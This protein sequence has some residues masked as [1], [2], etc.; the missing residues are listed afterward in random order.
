MAT[1]TDIGIRKKSAT[2]T[3]NTEKGI[4]IEHAGSSC[5]QKQGQIVYQNL[6]LRANPSSFIL[7]TPRLLSL[8]LSSSL[9]RNNNNN[10]KTSLL[11]A[12]FWS[13]F[14]S[15]T[16]EV[17]LTRIYSATIGFHYA[18]LIIS[19]ALGGLGIGALLTFT[20][21]SKFDYPAIIAAT[22]ISLPLLLAF[23]AFVPANLES[24]YSYFIVSCIPFVLSG[25]ILAKALRGD[26][27]EAP[28]IYFSDL[29]AASLGPPISIVLLYLFPPQT[30]LLASSLAGAA[31]ATALFL[32]Q[33]RR[34]QIFELKEEGARHSSFPRVLSLIVAA[35]LICSA[36]IAFNYSSNALSNYATPLKPALNSAREHGYDQATVWNPISRVDVI[37]SASARPG[38][39]VI[40]DPG[41][42][43][44]I[45][46][47]I[48]DGDASTP[49]LGWNGSKPVLPV[50][51]FMLHIPYALG[52]RTSVL[53]IGSGGGTDI[54]EALMS[55]ASNITAV[56]VN[57]AVVNIVKSYGARAGNIYSNPKVH[58]FI[59]EGRSFLARS[60]AK[61]DLIDMTLVD[62]WAAVSTGAYSTSEAYLYTTNAIQ[63]M[64]DHLTPSGTLVIVRWSFELPKDILTISSA[65]ENDGVPSSEVGSHIAVFSQTRTGEA[66]T[67][68]GSQLILVKKTPF[69]SYELSIM[70]N[71]TP[72]NHFYLPGSNS[73]SIYGKYF[74]NNANPSILMSAFPS[75][76]IVPAT[77]NSPYYFD[78]SKGVPFQLAQALEINL[79]I[80]AVIGII[81]FI[82]RSS[83]KR[84]RQGE[85]GESD[86]SIALPSRWFAYYCLIGLGFILIEVSLFQRLTLL[87]GYPTIAFASL[88]F[89]LLVSSACGSLFSSKIQNRAMPITLG[90]LC[91]LIAAGTLVLLTILPMAIDRT[92]S[93]G[94]FERVGVS[95]LVM[96]PLGVL[97]G[98][99]FPSGLR[100]IS[101]RGY[102]NASIPTVLGVNFIASVIG[103]VLAVIIGIYAGLAFS[104]VVAA[105]CYSIAT[106]IWLSLSTKK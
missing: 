62:S 72:Y 5:T 67:Y 46:S 79:G 49:I 22:A 105:I 14:Q 69:T 103:S 34:R 48:I 1:K 53:I 89:F 41:N 33:K 44:V 47:I 57:P 51:K 56:E 15:I 25:L 6:F 77:D 28:S 38:T 71:V 76:N 55:G 90:I 73:S 37:G 104:L 83:R 86:R 66:S 102:T 24:L 2:A 81:A 93:L 17:L 106:L 94:I 96:A 84:R 87:I 43:G 29:L 18:Y 23:I 45:G 70:R 95:G 50:T 92:L 42:A 61:Y 10:K 13:S 39:T 3:C 64:L 100:W 98:M 40:A 58:P 19:I 97:M 12:V 63:L 30:I 32:Q 91:A 4:A 75:Q 68:P 35:L 80:A 78:F 16:L 7:S 20:K 26:S 74:A 52:P 54:V 101:A 31:L 36:L 65:L 21:L 59:D 27:G 9:S 82:A 60:S 85:V 11:A 99:P 8:L 88:L